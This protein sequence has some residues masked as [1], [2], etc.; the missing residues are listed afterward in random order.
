MIKKVIKDGYTIEYQD[1]TKY[2]QAEI[3]RMIA[4][5]ITMISR[6]EIKDAQERDIIVSCWYRGNE[7]GKFYISEYAYQHADEL[8]ANDMFVKEK[9]S[10]HHFKSLEEVDNFCSKYGIE[11]YE[12]DETVKDAVSDEAYLI[13]EDGS[14]VEKGDEVISFRGEKAFVKGWQL[15]R[16][17]GKSGRVYVKWDGQEGEMGYYPEVFGLKWVGLPWQKEETKDIKVEDI[18]VNAPEEKVNITYNE[19]LKGGK[20]ALTSGMIEEAFKNRYKD[21]GKTFAAYIDVVLES[22]KED[23]ANAKYIVSGEMKPVR[24]LLLEDY[25]KI[26]HLLEKSDLKEKLAEMKPLVDELSEKLNLNYFKQPKF[27]KSEM[28]SAAKELRNKHRWDSVEEFVVLASDEPRINNNIFSLSVEQIIKLYRAG[29]I[30]IAFKGSESECDRFIKQVEM[31]DE[32]E[33]GE[34][35]DRTNYIMHPASIL[36]DGKVE[37][38]T[39]AKKIEPIF[40]CS[41]SDLTASYNDAKQG[42]LPGVFEGNLAK[43]EKDIEADYDRINQGRD[44]YLEDP[45][46][47]KVLPEIIELY[48]LATKYAEDLGYKEIAERFAYMLKTIKKGWGL[49]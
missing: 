22:L 33:Y 14:K 16:F 28:K 37:D 43:V 12:L 5:A 18:P 47:V 31:E 26:E 35:A 4:D 30:Y 45:R 21:E 3:D 42:K 13:H 9:R 19:K 1:S 7:K 10:A 49:E 27:K 8:D 20:S 41:K 32:G 24:N 23:I 2:T 34:E 29:K 25:V 39:I 17:Q 11:D 15:P 6:K 36:K 44:H 46:I 40:L 48:E 38:S